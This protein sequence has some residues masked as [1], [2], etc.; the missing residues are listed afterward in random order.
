MVTLE[1]EMRE[2]RARAFWET[3]SPVP[4]VR[5]GWRVRVLRWLRWRLG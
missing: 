1:R 5:P 3:F 4:Y 2:M